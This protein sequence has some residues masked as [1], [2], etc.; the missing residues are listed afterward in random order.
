MP[1]SYKK[2]F[3]LFEEKGIT[4]YT[5]RKNNIM[6][7]SALTKMKNGTGSIDTR[8]IEKLCAILDCQPGDIMEYVPDDEGN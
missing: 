4:T 8:T 5:I 7:Q 3:R 1:M 6:S 2:L